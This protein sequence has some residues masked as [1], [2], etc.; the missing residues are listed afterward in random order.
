MAAT[1]FSGPVVSAAGFESGAGA[2][3][4]V[5]AARTF[6][7]A[8]AGKTFGLNLAGGGALTMPAAST[9]TAGW[10]I[11][12]RLETAITTAWIATFTDTE[13]SG[14]IG[15][16]D[17][18]T[19]V[20]GSFIVAGEVLTFTASEALENNFCEGIFISYCIITAATVAASRYGIVLA[21]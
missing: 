19:T 21:V 9:I 8:D 20:D 11:R 1:H 12:L 6:T 16:V 14:N 18:V 5:V 7:Q 17:I 4:S 15:I 13:M 3:E 2:Y 10:K